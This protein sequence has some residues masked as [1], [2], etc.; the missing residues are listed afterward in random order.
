MSG[1]V[2]MAY[3][4]FCK[5]VQGAGHIKNGKPREDYGIKRESEL[6]KVFALGDGHG[7]SNCPRSEL[8][9]RYICEIA[10]EELVRFANDLSE[11]GWNSK[12]FDHAEVDKLI[13]QLV[14]SI[15]G[16]WSCQVNDDFLQN[17]LTEKE[18][19]EAAEY[20]ERYKKGERIEHAYG[21]TFIAGLMTDEYLL[22]LQQGD[23]RCVVFN[24]DGSVSQPIPW[25]NRCFAN[26]TTSVCDIDAV[27]SCRYHVI[28]LSQNRAIACIAGSDGVEDSFPSSMDK[29]HAYYRS[30]LKIACEGG[31][32]ALENHL[33]LTLPSLSENGSS[34]DITICGVIDTE[35]FAEKLD[36]MAIEN[37]IITL[38]D[39]ISSAQE[40]I[41]SM[42]NK[43]NF[44]R[45]KYETVMHEYNEVS[46]RYS[47]FMEEYES[48]QK[49]IASYEQSD[50]ET[51]EKE[52][53]EQNL[54]A[55]A[56]AIFNNI[57]KKALSSSSLRCLQERLEQMT[58][59]KERLENELEKVGLKKKA[60]EEEYFPYKEK[61]DGFV[62]T[63][64]DAQIR[65]NE[66]IG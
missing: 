64:E 39:K 57:K 18:E 44:L 35:L 47:A 49:D 33:D 53:S 29:M 65:L 32:E 31:V 62:R 16:K 24:Q 63:K 3:D 23:G 34:D 41:D 56:A 25:D 27:Q 51:E 52:D 17:P 26:V 15:F 20:I 9:S 38:R 1:G 10:A 48:I 36:I 60:L 7:D 59:E 30:I 58:Q 5:S 42:T 13:K 14:T 45:M 21:T 22:L 2:I 55:S 54:V 37:E 8:G 66:L 50:T 40:R 11:H 6:C 46:E 43:L 28:D 61:Y 19:T 4:L 12:L